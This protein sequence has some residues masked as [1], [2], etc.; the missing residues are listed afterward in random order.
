MKKCIINM[1]WCNESGTWVAD[2]DDVP[3]LALGADTFDELVN[4]V[5]PIVPELL[6]ENLS[7]KGPYEIH[8]VSEC[9]Y[10]MAAAS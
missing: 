1:I 4:K 9:I 10:T 5:R 8:F 3:G 6:E 2:S 7:Y